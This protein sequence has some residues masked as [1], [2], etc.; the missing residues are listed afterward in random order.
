MGVVLKCPVDV[1]LLHL[2]GCGLRNLDRQEASSGLRKIG[3][4]HS[5]GKPWR[6]T[7]VLFSFEEQG[8][9]QLSDPSCLPPGRARAGI[10]RVFPAM[11]IAAGSLEPGDTP[12][13]KMELCFCFET[14][15]GLCPSTSV[16]PGNFLS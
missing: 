10:H 16:F 9:K 3:S 11:N 8:G 15:L 14:C 1:F 2:A 6:K 12:G 4:V 13:L 5:R 7:Q